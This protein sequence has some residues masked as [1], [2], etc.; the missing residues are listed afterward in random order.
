MSDHVPA[1]LLGLLASR[2]MVLVCGSGGVGKT[3]TAAAM[4]ASA[5][6]ELGGRVLVVTVDPAR[7]LADALG[8]T[9]IGNSATRVGDE[10]FAE[11]G[12]EP[13]GELW[14][15]MLATTAGWDELIERHAPDAG[16]RAAVLSNPLYDNITRR[17]VHS[18]DYLAMEQ[19]HE[20]H[21]S[22]QWDLVIV[23][24]PPSRNALDVLDAPGRMKEFF[25]S[26]LLRWLTVPYRSR[27]FTVASRPFYQVADRVLGS[28]FLQDIAEFFILFQA[29]EGPFVKHAAEVEQLISDPRTAFVV[30]STL[31]AAPSYEAAYLARAL[32]ERSLPL[33][34]IVANRVLPE[35][36]AGKAAAN[37]AERLVDASDGELA[38]AVGEAVDAEP[39]QVASV[40]HEIGSRFADL[41]IVATREAERRRELSA[42]ADLFVALPMLDRDVNDVADL[43]ALGEAFVA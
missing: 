38:V 7:R 37:S 6:A 19:L 33:G 20:L 22:G 27:L 17:F 10:A 16:V 13:R 43:L 28:R 39:D 24:T 14:V 2:E 11:A 41:R 12:V 4:A 36:F 18:H 25:G 21:A 1:D 30:V 9:D 26:R 23:D 29:M 3:T 5:A 15:Q 40:L 32:H 42:L 34:A 35:R 31:E 8:I